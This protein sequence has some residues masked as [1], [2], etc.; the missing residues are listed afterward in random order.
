[1]AQATYDD[2]NL[3][4]KLYDLRREPKMREARDWYVKNFY[5]E[6]PEGLLQVAPMGSQENAYMRQV[7]SY[8]DMAASFITSG[9]LNQELFFQT[10]GELLVVW[11]RI[12]K[13]VPGM[14]Q[15]FKNPNF[16]KNM[17]TV[18]NSFIAYMG[19]EAYASFIERVGRPGGQQ[20]KQSA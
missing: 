9:V 14:R 10:G 3:I 13:S 15:F 6:S 16:L 18:A 12:E 1:M 2:A 7:F 5:A 4:L 17:E 20:Q 19:Q 11:A 8:W